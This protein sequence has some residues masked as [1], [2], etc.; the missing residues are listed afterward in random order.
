M[1][2]SV[3][4]NSN[5]NDNDA[6]TNTYLPV[7]QNLLL[8]N[9]CPTK[10]KR[11]KLSFHSFSKSRRKSFNL[12]AHMKTIKTDNKKRHRGFCRALCCTELHISESQSS[13]H[14]INRNNLNYTH[15]TT[16][17]STG[18]T[19]DLCLYSSN[20]SNDAKT[21]PVHTRKSHL[22]DFL[23]TAPIGNNKSSR[24]SVNVVLLQH[25][26]VA[27]SSSPS[28]HLFQRPLSS[29][30]SLHR[31]QTYVLQPHN[32]NNNNNN[33][34]SPS[35]KEKNRTPTLS[36]TEQNAVK[37]TSITAPSL[38]NSLISDQQQHSAVVSKPPSIQYSNHER[39][40]NNNFVPRAQI[41]ITS[42]SL[43]NK[44]INCNTRTSQNT[45]NQP[46]SS[47]IQAN[48][49]TNQKIPS[50][51]TNGVY[52]NVVPISI[53]QNSPIS[54]NRSSTLKQSPRVHS[55]HQNQ[56]RSL[57]VNDSL[58][59]QSRYPSAES[60]PSTGNRRR[61]DKTNISLGI[62]GG[63]GSPKTAE[64]KS[65]SAHVTRTKH[66][67]TTVNKDRNSQVISETKM[68]STRTTTSTNASSSNYSS[69][70]KKQ[71]V[72]DSLRTASS[73]AKQH[74]SDNTKPKITQ[75]TSQS[76]RVS[77]ID[78]IIMKQ[79]QQEKYKVETPPKPRCS[80]PSPKLITPP[81]E[82][83]PST[84]NDVCA[85]SLLE[86]DGDYSAFSNEIYQDSSNEEKKNS[87]TL[88]TILKP[89]ISEPISK[90]KC[91]Q[92]RPCF[93]SDVV[94]PTI[95]LVRPV[96]SNELKIFSYSL[97]EHDVTKK[98]SFVSEN[99]DSGFD[100]LTINRT[101]STTIIEDETKLCTTTITSTT[102]NTLN[103]CITSFLYDEEVDSSSESF[104]SLHIHTKDQRLLF[105]EENLKATY[106]IDT[107]YGRQTPSL[108][109]ESLS[110][111]SGIVPD[112]STDS[113]NED[114]EHE[115]NDIGNIANVS[116]T[117]NNNEYLSTLASTGKSTETYG[118]LMTWSRIKST[119]SSCENSC[120]DID[121][122]S[123]SNKRH[124]ISSYSSRETLEG[125][126][127]S[128]SPQMYDGHYRKRDVRVAPNGRYF[129]L[130]DSNNNNGDSSSSVE[131][132]GS[133]EFRYTSNYEDDIYPSSS[134]SPP[135]VPSYLRRKSDEIQIRSQSAE[136]Q[137]TVST[138]VIRK[139]RSIPSPYSSSKK[140]PDA[141]RETNQGLSSTLI[142]APNEI[143][144][145]VRAT[146]VQVILSP[147][148]VTDIKNKTP[149]EPSLKTP[150]D[151][152]Q[153]LNKKPARRL[154][155]PSRLGR[156]LFFRRV[157]SDSDIY[158]KVC[159]KENEIRHNV[160]HLDTI[161]DYS[162]EY[163]MITT[164][165]S[166]SQLR[167]W[168][169][170]YLCFR[171]DDEENH[172]DFNRMTSSNDD[173]EDELEFNQ[174]MGDDELDWYSEDLESFNIS[175]QLMSVNS[176]DNVEEFLRCQ[177]P[178]NTIVQPF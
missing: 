51:V 11:S 5:N 31:S 90:L 152:R 162:M 59:V 25:K 154:V 155:F 163:Y 30:A 9:C 104:T 34:S 93:S 43:M 60:P 16:A 170:D 159:S 175:S 116:G 79:Q 134:V 177:Q 117:D 131:R 7:H 165:G 1:V 109:S 39:L 101:H 46:S 10:P 50:R 83:T 105:V 157:L 176:D 78:E 110:F 99:K 127:Y 164:F 70:D 178:S 61:Y 135:L 156:I 141:V 140:V 37:I 125:R 72:I 81:R 167:A 123:S 168:M 143:S 94:R 48:R 27:S 3:N 108:G 149:P 45:Y 169:D 166:D 107:E 19:N 33:V 49:N 138:A 103:D 106:S 139:I 57:V 63:R 91:Q 2:T 111:L 121:C 122:Y 96:L 17:S 133:D 172:D 32:N 8:S 42:D 150:T 71:T 114:K 151:S 52:Q 80:T 12:I 58:R 148:P 174:P 142:T 53:V 55:D 112:L 95:T 88:N 44:T 137:A 56:V 113:L 15:T 24:P 126:R 64:L 100:S 77:N 14:S 62:N 76:Q 118:P 145:I 87:S 23:T 41:K 119:R 66:V 85:F 67:P 173:E 18:L 68:S 69:V 84:D 130:I 171:P 120:D 82:K 74:L 144:H 128:I 22:N 6:D 21:T 13:V 102:N 29:P 38:K 26:Q 136:P 20:N 40:N 129:L 65:V 160:Y 146:P 97:D 73:H 89:S 47:R 161:R 92:L 36:E 75:K 147:P 124:K 158:Q 115:R 54:N 153:S 132:C 86:N 35:R 4:D 98:R 28:Q